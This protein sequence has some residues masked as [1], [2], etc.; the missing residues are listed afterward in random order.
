MMESPNKLNGTRS[1]KALV[2]P[3]IFDEA[4]WKL[5]T[6]MS[7]AHQ[8]RYERDLSKLIAQ[9]LSERGEVWGVGLWPDAETEKIAHQCA[10]IIAEE[11]AID[12]AALNRWKDNGVEDR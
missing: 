8:V 12:R 6:K 4:E 7:F 1:A 11:Y 3:I 2:T 10:E 9:R 5:M